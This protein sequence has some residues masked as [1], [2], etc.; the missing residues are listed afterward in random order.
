M[1]RTG[2]EAGQGIVRED[3]CHV[4]HRADSLAQGD[5]LL[6][7]RPF[8]PAVLL[9]PLL[10]LA[11]APLALIDAQPPD[12]ALE[13]VRIVLLLF[14]SSPL[15]VFALSFSLDV[16]VEVRRNVDLESFVDGDASLDLL[17]LQIGTQT[18]AQ[19]SNAAVSTQT[20]SHRFRRRG[21]SRDAPSGVFFDGL[22]DLVLLWQRNPALAEQQVVH[23]DED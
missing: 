3:A 18:V 23:H 17:A 5:D 1:R 6:Q 22:A 12:L 4:Q 20:P 14:L 16:A 13:A 11:H 15:L 10:G 2:C 8:R 21:D 7:R 19:R 9:E